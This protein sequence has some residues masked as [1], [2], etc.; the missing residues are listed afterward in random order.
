MRIGLVE[1]R[2]ASP[3]ERVLT[4]ADSGNGVSQRLRIEEYL[5]MNPD[6]T[7]TLHRP[8][9]GEWVGLR[10]RTDFVAEGVGVAD[11]KLYDTR[12]PIGRGVQTLM[13]RKRG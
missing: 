13:V 10:A 1:G 3:L 2:L 11:S 12:G 7:V 4:A 5:Y 9:G 6:L 8:L